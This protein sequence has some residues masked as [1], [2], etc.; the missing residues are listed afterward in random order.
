M[1]FF[2]VNKKEQHLFGIYILFNYV[3]VFTVPLLKNS[4]ILNLFHKN[5][6]LYQKY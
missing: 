4:I 1:H 3:Q 5:E 6:I 2:A